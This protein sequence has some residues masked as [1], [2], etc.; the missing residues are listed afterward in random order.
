MMASRKWGKME[1]G[2]ENR[3]WNGREV[4][5]KVKASS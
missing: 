3:R 2:R 1:Q 4:Q 5:T